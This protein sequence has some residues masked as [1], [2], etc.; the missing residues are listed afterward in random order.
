MRKTQN[1][2]LLDKLNEGA[3]FNFEEMVGS[4]DNYVFLRTIQI[5]KRYRSHAN[6]PESILTC[7]NI[8]FEIEVDYRE[9]EPQNLESCK[10]EDAKVISLVKTIYD[11]GK[12]FPMFYLDQYGF[13]E[14]CHVLVA[15][16]YVIYFF[17]RYSH[18]AEEDKESVII[19]RHGTARLVNYEKLIF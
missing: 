11:Q 17:D 10:E 3:E 6:P 18:E 7:T 13:K 5:F 2:K 4:P 16:P 19:S 14:L 12:P 15:P 1:Q 8:K 9:G